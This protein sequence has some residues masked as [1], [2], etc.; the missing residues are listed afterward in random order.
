VSTP[1]RSPK[2]RRTRDEAQPFLDDIVGEGGDNSAPWRTYICGSYRRGAPDIGDFDILVMTES[3][4]FEDYPFPVH[5]VAQ[6]RGDLIVQGD[7]VLP[8][9]TMHADFYSC[10][11]EQRGAFLMFLT[12][13][14]ALNIQQRAQAQKIGYKLT[15]YGLF[16]RTGKQIDDGTEQDIYKRLGIPYKT[17]TERQDFVEVKP[18]EDAQ[19][20]YFEEPSDSGG[21]PYRVRVKGEPSNLLKGQWS[22]PCKSFQYSRTIPANCKHIDRRKKKIAEGRV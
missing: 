16:D 8:E 10:T 22:C 6:H 13:P 12:G 15:Q 3:G 2:V 1:W 7:I 5:F 4:T 11:R 14:K 19:V 17:A 20:F 21:E 18:P 9:G